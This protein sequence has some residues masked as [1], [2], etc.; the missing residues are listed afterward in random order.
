MFTSA[1]ELNENSAPLQY[2]LGLLYEEL[3]NDSK[4]LECYEHAIRNDSLH[5]DRYNESI[6]PVVITVSGTSYANPRSMMKASKFSNALSSSPQACHSC[7]TTWETCIWS[8]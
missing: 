3:G 6:T 4:A 8:W 1:T 5:M 2:Q 7:I